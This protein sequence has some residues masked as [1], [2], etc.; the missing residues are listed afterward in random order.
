VNAAATGNRTFSTASAINTSDPSV[1]AGTPAALFQTE[2]W[3]PAGAPELQWSFPVTPGGYEVRLYFAE[4]YSGIQSAGARVFN[5]AIEG[6]PVLT[7]FDVYAAVGANKGLMKSFQVTSDSTLTIDFTHVKENPAV[8]GIEILR[9]SAANQ[10]GASP[11]ALDFGSVAVNTT[12]TKPL[13]L[14]NLGSAGAL[15]LEAWVN[16]AALGTTWR[17]VLFKE[18]S[19][20]MVYSLY[21]NEAT[22]R[23][24]GQV[25]IGGEQNALGSTGLPLNTWT[26]LAVT[27]DGRVLQLY[28]NGMVVGSK[29]QTGAVPASSGVLRMGGNGIWPEWFSGRLDDVRVYNRALTQTEIQADMSTQ[30]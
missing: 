18:Q 7:N 2:R 6:N 14:T 3:D 22:G 9:N 19:A 10:L 13:Q 8:K 24:I 23:P 16:P 30:V 20:G 25:N 21:A 17:T 29:A 1:P 5:V 15:T 11:A 28:V 26:H 12:S 27:Y 4:I